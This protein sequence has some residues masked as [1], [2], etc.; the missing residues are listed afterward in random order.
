MAFAGHVGVDVDISN[1]SNDIISVLFNEELGGVIQVLNSNLTE[2]ISI[3]NSLKLPHEVIGK[4][5]NLL[6]FNIS[7]NNTSILQESLIELRKVWSET[8]YQI[9]SIRDNADC[10][11]QENDLLKN[12]DNAGLHVNLTF[13]HNNN[14]STPYINIGHRPRVVILREQGVN[15]HIEMASAFHHVGFESV[16][17]HMS[18]VL[19]GDVNFNDFTGL[20][21]CG[22]F[23]YGDVLGAGGGWAKSILFHERL[24]DH[25]QEF[26]HRKDSFS[27]G[28]CNGCQMLSNLKEL[29]PGA[30]LWPQFIKNTSEQFEARFS[31]VKIRKSNS[32]LLKGMQDSIIPIAVAH[33]EGHAKFASIESM[34]NALSHD[35]V[36]MQYVDNKN[37]AT[38]HYPLNPNGSV[39]GIT[40]LTTNDGRVTIMMPHPE[41]VYRTVQNSWHPDDWS[42]D[43]P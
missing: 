30:E 18:D 25:F 15:G 28:V 42:E 21:A 9:Q 39:N 5:N 22:G 2:T 20:V 23:S 31:L 3:L 40:G 11:K 19:S 36:C 4:L 17:V 1:L 10:A 26:F 32:I 34:R 7:F 24:K 35:T 12:V 16:D 33:G 41:R 29:I 43:A 13:D 8:S 38:E 27:F 6:Q 14:I 37:E